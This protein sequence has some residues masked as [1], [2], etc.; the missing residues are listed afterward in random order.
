MLRSIQDLNKLPILATDGEIGRVEQCFF[1]NREYE[2][3]LHDYYGRPKYW[4][5]V[6]GIQG[7]LA[8]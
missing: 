8:G 4:A 7:K 1:I 5:A 2:D 3:R 6:E